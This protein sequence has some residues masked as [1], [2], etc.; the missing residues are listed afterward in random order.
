MA[1]RVI[2]TNPSRTNNP[3]DL[4]RDTVYFTNSD[5]NRYLDYGGGYMMIGEDKDQN[6]AKRA[7]NRASKVKRVDYSDYKGK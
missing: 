4:Q 2:Y 3:F 1:G 5:N 6:A 7:F